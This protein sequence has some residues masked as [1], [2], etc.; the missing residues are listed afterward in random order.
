[1]TSGNTYRMRA[2]GSHLEYFSHGRVNPFGISFDPLGNMYIADCE[3]LPIFLHLRGAY[4]PSFGR[5]HDGLGFGP[6]MLDHMHGSSAIAGIAYYAATQFPPEYRDA[7]FIGNPVTNA[8]CYDRLTPRGSFYWAE[9]Q[10]DFLTSDDPWFR[11]VDVKLG[12]DG[13]L[14]I[15]DFYNRIIGHYEV[16]LT[17][18]GRD[19]ERGRIWRIV[20]VGTKEKP[21]TP[22]T[23][24][25]LAE[26]TGQQLI[27]RLADAN[28]TVRTL[29]TNELVDRIG[30]AVVAPLQALLKSAK[31]TATQRAHGLWVL[32]RLGALDDDL[33]KRLADDPDRLVRV[34]LIKALAEQSAVGQVFQP[35]QDKRGRPY[36]EKNDR[37]GSLSYS[38]IRSKLNDPDP[39][40]RRAAADAL[41][42]HPNLDT[43]RPL[44]DLWARTP[45][46]D[47]HLIHT[48]R[49]ALRDHLALP[50]AYAALAERGIPGK[51]RALWD[52]M[53]DVSLGIPKADSATFLLTLLQRPPRDAAQTAEYLHH[54]AR[55]LPT[56]QL[57]ELYDLL[58]KWRSP[59]TPLPFREGPGEGASASSPQPD[60][61]RQADFVRVVHQGLQERGL[62]TFPAALQSWG[63]EV[64][65]RL[66][67]TTNAD[68]IARGIDLARELHI[69]PAYDRLAALAGDA[70][71]KNPTTRPAAIDACVALDPVRSVPWL[72]DLVG[73]GDESL[74]VRQKA[75]QGLMM[76]NT[77]PARGELLRR[78]PAAPAELASI[79]A[80]CLAAS[81]EGSELLL[82]AVREGKA[83]ARLLREPAVRNR[84]DIHGIPN[85]DEQVRTLTANLKPRDNRLYQLIEQRRDGYLN[86]KTRPD[87]ALGRP[88]FQKN[89]TVC[90][91]MGNEGHKIGPDL[92]GIGIRGLDRLLEDVLDP[93]RVVDQ[94]FRVTLI[95]T[96]DGRSLSG[97]VVREEG[98]IVVLVDQAGKEQRIA[99]TAIAAR[100]VSTL[101]PM[102]SNFGD[103]LTK[104]QLY[105]LMSFLLSQRQAGT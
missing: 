26:M 73:R 101:S 92:D 97:L 31:S 56:E 5:P 19:R 42:A 2:D 35:D 3:T 64:A 70:T 59:I 9:L 18:P 53:A 102:P 54:A 52:R 87:P 98:E 96:T 34:H 60:L 43:V 37:L 24:P 28:L 7:I 40:V 8:I 91:R 55:Y 20:Y 32:Q 79:I 77:D 27:E 75:A 46:E 99:K 23:I 86:L 80:A 49:I 76:I 63:A 48:L 57:P 67:F 105:Q 103:L 69:A 66:L 45:A 47:T 78:L 22:S 84:L 51:E 15:A 82:T 17:H 68:Q 83:S 93:N 16:P 30:P 94:A 81:R 65:R 100:R 11:P 95:E 39:F 25:K 58:Q 38:L 33:V 1:M 41:G 44:C 13:A 89:C 4:Y 21:A 74:A 62:T 10:P 72:S 50:G 36:Q 85:L 88:L 104:Q 29:A 90:H 14:Y 6:A 71:Q 12:P 61:S